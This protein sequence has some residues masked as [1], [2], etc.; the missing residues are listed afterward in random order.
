MLPPRK[1]LIGAGFQGTQ[2]HRRPSPELGGAAEAPLP[3]GARDSSSRRPAD[4]GSPEGWD[5][6]P[7]I[8]SLGTDRGP[9]TESPRQY[10]DQCCSRV[11]RRDL[12]PF[13]QTQDPRPHDFR[14]QFRIEWTNLRQRGGQRPRHRPGLFFPTRPRSGA[15]RLMLI[16]DEHSG[17]SFSLSTPSRHRRSAFGPS[18]PANTRASHRFDVPAPQAGAGEGIWSRR[19]WLTSVDR[20]PCLGWAT[21]ST[22]FGRRRCSTGTSDLLTTVECLNLFGDP[23]DALS[24]RPLTAVASESCTCRAPTKS[25]H[26]QPSPTQA[27]C[28]Q[29][30]ALH[31]SVLLPEFASAGHLMRSAGR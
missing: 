22:A 27:T 21:V 6:L 10:D 11:V 18:R 4:D 8:V 31:L 13:R 5:H 24:P 3:R 29:R 9:P 2:T 17:F 14:A 12:Q 15:F 25:G 23:N 16:Y 28:N 7:V 26:V 19:A 1:A 30:P 20:H